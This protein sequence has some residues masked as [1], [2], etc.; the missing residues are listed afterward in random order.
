MKIV[1]IDT[2]IL[3]DFFL[4]REKFVTAK[5]IINQVASGK[6]KLLI[7]LPVILEFEWTLK[8]FYKTPKKII[9]DRI[10]AVLE[11]PN[12]EIQEK[13]AIKNALILYVDHS[14]VSFDDCLIISQ[15]K[16][17]SIRIDEFI[18]FDKKLQ[19]LYQKII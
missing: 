16:I 4:E 3:L 18:T 15:L 7:L 19:K 14:G 6:I 17:F 5:N 2:N 13:Q 11:L 8:R 9:M 12:C 1:A 10:K